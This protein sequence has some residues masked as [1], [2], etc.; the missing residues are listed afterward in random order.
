MSEN[1]FA[2]KIA[3]HFFR[4]L[5]WLIRSEGILFGV[6]MCD[7]SGCLAGRLVTKWEPESLESLLQRKHFFRRLG[8]L[9]RSKGGMC[10]SSG[11]S[12]RLVTEWEPESL[13]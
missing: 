6:G 4:H 13:E 7:S 9:I 5:G 10:D 12:G 11:L 3:K 8:W 1:S 2:K